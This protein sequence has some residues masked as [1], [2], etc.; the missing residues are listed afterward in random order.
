MPPTDLGSPYTA[1]QN[2]QRPAPPLARAIAGGGPG[3]PGFRVETFKVNGDLNLFHE[4]WIME[5]VLD[6][7]YLRSVAVVPFFPLLISGNQ[8]DFPRWEQART[9][10]PGR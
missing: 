10:P 8:Y 2:P 9:D 1:R 7:S 4:D 6:V 3:Q 5:I